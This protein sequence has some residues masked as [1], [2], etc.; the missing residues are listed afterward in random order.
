M[1]VSEILITVGLTVAGSVAI[2]Y[3]TFHLQ[4][5]SRR[6]TLFRALLSEVRWNRSLVEH[7]KDDS[8]KSLKRYTPLHTV[9]YQNFRLTGELLSLPEPIRQNLMYTYEMINTHNL[10]MEHHP[11]IPPSGVDFWPRN[12]EILEK[13]NSLEV[14]LRKTVKCLK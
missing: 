14:E 8:L 1:N 13:L 7:L 2:A 5:K 10:E 3:T 11:P 6:K 9:A 12:D 4:A